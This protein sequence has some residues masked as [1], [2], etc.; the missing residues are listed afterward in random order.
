MP[1]QINP[2]AFTNAFNDERD[3]GARTQAYADSQRQQQFQNARVT[4]ADA[5]NKTQFDNQQADRAD[6][7]KAQSLGRVGAIAQKALTLTDPMQRKGF[8]QQAVGTYGKDFAALG[9]DTSKV[10]DM[11]AMP[12]EQ[13]TGMLQQAAQFAPEAKPIEVA[14]GGSIVVKDPTTGGYKQ[15]YSNP[16]TGDGFTLAPEAIRFDAN[17][18]EIARGGPKS[19]TLT[20]PEGF[21]IAAKLRGEYNK[22]S[23]EFTS[24]ADAYQRIKDSA[25]NPSAAGDLSLIFN[26]MKV[27][28]PGS[29]VREGEFATAQNA[30]SIPARI[31]A[32][33]NKVM[34]GERLAPEQRSDFVGRS[35]QLYKGQENRFNT[36][37][38]SRYEALAKR[39]GLDPSE[40]LS[41]PSTSQAPGT[42]A[43]F[44]SEQEA[45]AAGLKTGTKVVING[46]SGTWQE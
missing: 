26:F 7:Q 10:H 17:G 28:D 21:D 44:G 32:Q 25:S 38:K 14:K 41:D 11:L 36:R 23:A 15:A 45:E 4:E 27:L 30:G 12:D 33:Y 16:D 3:R 46:V 40:V 19:T 6:A 2:G 39:Y 1:S 9:S 13:L 34:S 43:Q 29:T 24:V 20:K 37:V 22:Q 31:T 5:Q 35:T 8:L 18:K 42:V